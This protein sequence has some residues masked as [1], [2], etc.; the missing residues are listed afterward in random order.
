MKLAL[1]NALRAAQ[2]GRPYDW[3]IIYL[4]HDEPTRP[5]PGTCWGDCSRP[6]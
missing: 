5:T 2:L 1:G 4:G 3:A 6:E